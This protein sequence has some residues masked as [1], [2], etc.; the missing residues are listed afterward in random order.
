[1]TVEIKTC[2][3]YGTK[4]KNNIRKYNAM[5]SKDADGKR[6]ILCDLLGSMGDNVWITSPCYVD[7]GCNIYFGNHCEVNIN[8]TFL[9]NRIIIG[10]YALLAPNV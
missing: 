9:D 1:M 6:A 5:D 7:C 8:C 2:Y 4:Q 3:S 10:D